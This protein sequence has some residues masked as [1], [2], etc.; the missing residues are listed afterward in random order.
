MDEEYE[1]EHEGSPE[2][3]VADFLQELLDSAENIP[4]DGED[5][6]RLV[7]R[8]PRAFKVFGRIVLDP[9]NDYSYEWTYSLLEQ[10]EDYLR[11]NPDVTDVCRFR[12]DIL[13][14]T[15]D[16]LVDIYTPGLTS[17]LSH[18]ASHMDYLTEVLEEYGTRDGFQALAQAQYRAIEET[19]YALCDRIDELLS[20][21]RGWDA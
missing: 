10:L 7:F 17:W 14:E 6:T 15:I 13:P 1:R 20:G 21:Q 2:Y 9:W 8:D 16:S 11:A 4:V 5:K 18:R 19:A 3:V 12:D